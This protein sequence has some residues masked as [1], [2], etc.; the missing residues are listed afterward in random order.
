MTRDAGGASC[1]MALSTAYER[2]FSSVVDSA[3]TEGA[4]PTAFFKHDHY[5]LRIDDRTA[6]TDCV[7]RL[8]CAVP[9]SAIT[10]D[11]SPEDCK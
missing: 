6:Q 1:V 2:R 7:I 11:A 8:S 10:Q 3:I 5:V 4:P 9:D